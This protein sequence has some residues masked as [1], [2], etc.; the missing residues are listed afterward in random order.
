MGGGGPLARNLTVPPPYPRHLGSQVPANG[1]IGHVIPTDWPHSCLVSPENSRIYRYKPING[2]DK[3][4]GSNSNNKVSGGFRGRF[5]G[6]FR[7]QVLDLIFDKFSK[8]E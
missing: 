5:R 1:L 2:F 6:R 7:G 4:F 3:D 8:F